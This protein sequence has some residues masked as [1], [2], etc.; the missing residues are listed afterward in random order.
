MRVRLRLFND[1]NAQRSTALPYQHL[2]DQD[3]HVIAHLHD[4]GYGPREIG[5]Q[6][7]RCAG[8]ISRELSRN[9]S[10]ADGYDAPAAQRSAAARR[11]GANAKRAK[12]RPHKPLLKVVKDGLKQR[13]SPK[14]ISERLKQQ[15]AS[16]GDGGALRVSAP[17]IY[18]WLKCDHAEGGRWSKKLPRGGRGRKPNGNKGKRRDPMA[19]RRCITERPPGAEN[20]SRLGH[21]EGDT[22]EGAHKQSFLVTLIDRKSRLGLIGKAMDKSSATINAVMDELLGRL[23]EGLRRTGTLD[24]GTEFSGFAQLE[25]QLDMTIYFAHPYS[26]WE[27]GSN[28]QFNGLLRMF[29]PKGTDFRYVSD[30][31]LAQIESMLNNRP[32]KCLN[33]RTPAEVFKPPWGVALR[34]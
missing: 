16:G 3:R 24:N 18:A 22:L 28:E 33:Y 8:T 31:K 34:T 10:S 15:R 32:R 29:L 25:E 5:R 11:S 17:T 26:P 21:W 19:G 7:G 13:W 14:L 4:R 9:G 30:T 23:P 6:L 20:R 27:R 2:T 1:F 12:L